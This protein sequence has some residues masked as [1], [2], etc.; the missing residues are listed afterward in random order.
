MARR[1]TPSRR[2]R[3]AVAAG[4]GVLTW[5]IGGGNALAA[6]PPLPGPPPGAGTGLPLPPA[7]GQAPAATV[8]G[9]PLSITGRASG[10]GLLGS[11][12]VSKGSIRVSVACRASGKAYLAIGHT[13]VSAAYR[14][15]GGQAQLALK[16]KAPA[17]KSYVRTESTP[18]TLRLVQSGATTRL[19]LAISSAAPAR[20]ISAFGLNCAAGGPLSAQLEAPNFTDVVPTTI[21]VRPWLAWYTRST[22][23]Q[24]IGTR[25]AGSSSWYRWTAAA[26]G[27]AEWRHGTTVTPWTWGPITIS[28]GHHMELVAVFEAIYWYGRPNDVWRYASAESKSQLAVCVYP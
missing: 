23:W 28:G 13:T 27:V 7:A 9:A 24:W 2:C 3:H 22:G 25:G 17:L 21:D 15:R 4:L 14:C 16:P 12:T 10:P 11:P 6:S 5:V 20:W 1:P 18:H 26:N 8:N 19:S